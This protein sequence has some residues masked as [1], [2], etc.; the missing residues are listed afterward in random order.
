MYDLFIAQIF[1]V[2][3]Q[4]ITELRIFFL[5]HSRTD[6]FSVA[7]VAGLFIAP[8]LVLLWGVNPF[9][10]F[11][12]VIS[13]LLFIINIHALQKLASGVLVDSYSFCFIALD[14]VLFILTAVCTSLILYFRPVQIAPQKYKVNRTKVLLTGSM[15]KGFTI[16]K[17]FF[18]K[19]KTT[20][21]LYIYESQDKTKLKKQTL[22]IT[23]DTKSD[24]DQYEPYMILMAQK[25]YRVLAADFYPDDY[26]FYSNILDTKY[27]R[28]QSSVYLSFI[29]DEQYAKKERN[30]LLFIQK[31]YEA[32]SAIAIDK[33][34]SNAKLFYIID[35][36]D[37]DTISRAYAKFKTNT[38]GVYPLN[39]IS[40][41]KS[42]GY[43]FIEQTSPLLARQFNLKR[44]KT[45]FIPRYCAN[46][47]EQAIIKSEQ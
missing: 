26:P 19:E 20:G 3:L 37:F 24:I 27:V 34:G 8:S 7:S 16:K 44:D 47:T 33:Y 22:I 28:R 11:L 38:A 1:V 5:H 43:G 36:I 21:K 46:K 25:G 4:L 23:T 40:E 10:L 15:T 2:F 14:F 39:R 41:Y 45:L 12:C 18:S 17:N 29:N 9:S 13:F 6:S 30:R 42:S 31:S 32:L 35:G